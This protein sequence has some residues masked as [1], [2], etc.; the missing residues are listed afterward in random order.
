MK[1]IDLTKYEIHDVR[2]IQKK[3][4]EIEKELSFL[5]TRGSISSLFVRQLKRTNINY[6]IKL[7]NNHFAYLTHM[8]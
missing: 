4:Y 2:K 7:Q 5:G 1:N 3:N 8:H 6:L